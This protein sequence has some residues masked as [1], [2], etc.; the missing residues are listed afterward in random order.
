MAEVTTKEVVVPSEDAWRRLGVTGKV[1]PTGYTPLNNQTM[2]QWDRDGEILVLIDHA[3]HWALGDWLN[4]GENRFSQ[5]ASQAKAMSKKSFDWWQQVR[6]VAFQV[7]PENR[8]RELP[9]SYHQAVAPLDDMPEQREL[10]QKAIDEKWDLDDLRAEV[11]LVKNDRTP[12]EIGQSNEPSAYM[13]AKGG[14]RCA[15]AEARRC[16]QG[17]AGR[18]EG[19]RDPE[20]PG[21]P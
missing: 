13:A 11:A 8:R 14:R 15:A 4:A 6:R 3:M 5:E 16:G 9:W 1:T 7:R 19:G 20:A 17:S 21:A 18:E 2:E 10:L 12:L